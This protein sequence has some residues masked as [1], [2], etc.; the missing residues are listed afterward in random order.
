MEMGRKSTKLLLDPINTARPSAYMQLFQKLKSDHEQLKADCDELCD[1][2]I[3]A[4]AA[5][6]RRGAKSLLTVLRDRTAALL[7]ELSVHSRWED[8]TLF[9]VFTR[10]YKKTIEPT[11]QPS[12]WVLE[13]DHELA[14]QF[15]ESFL[16]ASYAQLNLLAMDEEAIG[17]TFFEELK[18]GCHCLTQGCF[19]LNSH[20]QMEEE[21]IF[22]LAEEILTDIDYLFS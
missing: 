13:K 14:L 20:F 2:S 17:P 8:E 6:S 7:S 16:H 5:F 22:P 4:A 10:Y 9:P 3:R 11:I 21:L 18:E 15:F 19:I 1:L 12:L